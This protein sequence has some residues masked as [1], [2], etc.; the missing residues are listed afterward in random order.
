MYGEEVLDHWRNP[1]NFGSIESPSLVG[2][3]ENSSCGDKVEFFLREEKGKIL[4]VKWWGEGC[5]LC[6]AGA[7]LLSER[8]R[9]IGNLER[10]GRIGKD[11]VLGMVGIADL[12]PAREGCVTLGWEALRA[13][14]IKTNGLN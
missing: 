4:E 2:R 8:V 12:S 7:S 13:A 10:V 11:E 9:E 14:I 6:M 3:D 1:R 5:A